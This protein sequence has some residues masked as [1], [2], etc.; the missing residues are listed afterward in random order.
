MKY[1]RVGGRNLRAASS[2]R[3]ET[4]LIHLD[5]D[6]MFLKTTVHGAS[7]PRSE[8][9]STS[10]K[11]DRAVFL[12]VGVIVGV[13]VIGRIKGVLVVVVLFVRIAIGRRRRRRLGRL[14]RRRRRRRRRRGWRRRRRRRRR[15]GRRRVTVKEGKE[16]SGRPKQA[17]Q[18][19]PFSSSS[20]R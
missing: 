20:G 2:P 15:R 5:V 17:L 11:H 3:P 16:A 13:I 14:R 18:T 9:S 8:R 10:F 12:L 19:S 7:N 6:A 1:A 4:D